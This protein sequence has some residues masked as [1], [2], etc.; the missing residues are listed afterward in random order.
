MEP[1]IEGFCRGCNCYSK[2]LY[3]R[4]AKNNYTGKLEFSPFCTE[5]IKRFKLTL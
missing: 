2:Y 1:T 3:N 4:L 5:C